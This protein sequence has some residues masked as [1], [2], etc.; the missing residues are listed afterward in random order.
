MWHP[1]LNDPY[2]YD[3]TL[4]SPPNGPNWNSPQP[5]WGPTPHSETGE[6]SPQTLRQKPHGDPAAGLSCL[7]R[8]Q[9]GL[10]SSVSPKVTFGGDSE[11]ALAKD[12]A[13]CQPPG[14]YLLIEDTSDYYTDLPMTEE[15]GCI[16]NGRGRGLLLH[17]TLAMRIERWDLED[18]PRVL[19]LGLLR[20]MLEPMGFQ[21]QGAGNAPGVDEQ[22]AGIGA[23]GGGVGGGWAT[24]GSTWIYLRTGS[25]FYEPIERCQRWGADF[26]IEVF[27]PG[28]ERCTGTSRS[29]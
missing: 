22:V 1:F 10:V 8:T 27:T 17:T 25:D 21:A 24:G 5:N 15:L 20:R 13:A 28:L 29:R 2:Y 19:A 14:Q 11:A 7:E 23:L 26:V 9:S 12:R 16:G 3:H 4:L 18:R 6:D